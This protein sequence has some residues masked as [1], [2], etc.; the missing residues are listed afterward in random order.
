MSNTRQWPTEDCTRV[1]NWVYS[2]PENYQQELEKIFYGP[3]WSFVGLECEIPNAGDIKRSQ[4]GER[5]VL[6]TRDE[7]GDINVILNSCAHRA[8]EV[9]QKKFDNSTALMCP[10]HQWTYD[11][12][13]NLTGVPFRRGQKGAGG[14]P[15]EFDLKQHGMRKLRVESVN[16]AVFATF[17]ENALPLKEY[18]GEDVYTRF[19][20]VFDGRKIKVI[21]Y[22]R[23]RIKANW[24]LYPENMKDSYHA[25]LLHVFLIS[26]GLYRMDQEGLLFHDERTRANNVVASTATAKDKLAGKEEMISFKDSYALLD[27]R[28]VAPV[29]EFNDDITI[30]NITLFPAV[31]MQQQQNLLQFRN[32]VPIGPNE[33]DL[34]W[35]FFGYEDDDDEMTLRRTRLANLTGSSGYISVDDTEVFEFSRNGMLPNNDRNCVL[36]MGGYDTETPTKGDM[37]SE[38]A[39]RGFYEFY[40]KI[41]YSE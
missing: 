15:K 6:M 9:C 2:D 14:Y 35:T 11:L 38:S 4:V 8:A 12:K 22:Q 29:K 24:K 19:T 34:Q 41:M 33:F 17:D 18:M 36:E 23:Q 16:G 25:T 21:G 20:R 40:R 28:Q 32:V 37:V 13:G 7:A 39:I 30:Q 26:F 27:M 10:Y 31:T 1:P 3:F 5:S